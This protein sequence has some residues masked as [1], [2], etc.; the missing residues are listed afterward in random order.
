MLVLVRWWYIC[1]TRGKKITLL[2]C[3]INAKQ[4]NICW[5]IKS[6]AHAHMLWTKLKLSIDKTYNLEKYRLH[7]QERRR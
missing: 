6:V 7:Y 1:T 3:A 5:G 2:R 4:A